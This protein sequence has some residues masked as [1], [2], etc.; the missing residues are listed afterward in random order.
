MSATEQLIQRLAHHPDRVRPLRAPLV[1]TGIWLSLSLPYVAIVLLTMIMRHGLPKLAMDT[2]FIVECVSGLAVGIAAALSAFGSVVP[3][4]S[5][6]FF[7]VFAMLTGVWLGSV[8]ENCIQEWLR[9]GP[10]AL[11][12][13][14][15]LSCLPFIT[16][17]GIYPAVTLIVMLRRGAPL[18]PHVTAAVAA[19]AA[20]GLANFALRIAVPENANV[21]LFIWHV[22]G[23]L[24]LAALT[25]T[26]GHRL[27]NWRLTDGASQ[28]ISR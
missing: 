28:S 7:V 2:R 3:A 8:G 22:G 18:T 20:A 5:R 9:N 16:F 10:Q 23:V 27:L 11:S 17:V 13:N 21:G 4:Y 12:L 14:H 24:L 19:I 6:R 1:R 26:V 15:D 25:G